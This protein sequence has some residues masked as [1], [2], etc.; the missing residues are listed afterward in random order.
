[1]F[2]P[3]YLTRI[4]FAVSNT[5][6][7]TQFSLT[8]LLPVFAVNCPLVFAVLQCAILLNILNAVKSAQ[9]Q[10]QLYGTKN[11]C[12]FVVVFFE[13]NWTTKDLQGKTVSYRQVC[14]KVTEVSKVN[15]LEGFSQLYGFSFSKELW[16][17]LKWSVQCGI[18]TWLSH[19][20]LEE[21]GQ[22]YSKL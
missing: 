13:W 19:N 2:I 7:S 16:A 1:M 20:S 3:P 10:R 6:Y 15:I 18:Q 12:F 17:R 8:C 9:K 11:P 22:N 14:Y 5:V 21:M 4:V